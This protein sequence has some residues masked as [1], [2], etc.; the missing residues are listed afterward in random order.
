MDRTS[1]SDRKAMS[2]RNIHS[3]RLFLPHSSFT[4]ASEEGEWR[5]SRSSIPVNFHTAASLRTST[6]D[7]K[8]NLRSA[9]RERSEENFRIA[10]AALPD[11]TASASSMAASVPTRPSISSTRVAEIRPLPD[12]AACS[13]SDWPSRIE[14]KAYRAIRRKASPS[15]R[16]FSADAMS[17][18]RERISSSVSIRKSSRCTRERIVSGIRFGSVVAKMK[19]TWG[20]GSSRIFSSPLNADFESM[21]TSSMM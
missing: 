16:I 13:K 5:N 7:R 10:S 12:T 17:W 8:R 20:G 6:R 2:S 21:W 11:A 15:Q 14:P 9:P 19:T 4:R 1:F 3:S 18:R